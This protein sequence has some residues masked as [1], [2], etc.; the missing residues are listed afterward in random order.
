MGTKSGTSAATCNLIVPFT[1][2]PDKIATPE[3][4]SLKSLRAIPCGVVNL[5]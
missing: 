2:S 3:D 4:S 1:T 5:C